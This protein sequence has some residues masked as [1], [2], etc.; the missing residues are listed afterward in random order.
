M[1]DLHITNN[2]GETRYETVVDGMIAILEYDLEGETI[3]LRH[4]EVP[5]ALG[6]RGIGGAL[7]RFA[8]EDAK[9]RGLTVVPTCPF[10][11][12]YI[13]RHPEYLA[14]VREDYR[15]RVKPD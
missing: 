15:S 2:T 8:L 3:T 6:G 14:L 13:A 1:S 5:V 10:V 11:R 7:A 12:P 9:A 4:T